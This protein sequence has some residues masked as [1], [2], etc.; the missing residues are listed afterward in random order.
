VGCESEYAD[1][2]TGGMDSYDGLS[3]TSRCRMV[4]IE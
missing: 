4:L 2:L 3:P 1:G